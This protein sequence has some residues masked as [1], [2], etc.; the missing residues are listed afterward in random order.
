MRTRHE[1]S[2]GNTG[3]AFSNKQYLDAWSNEEDRGDAALVKQYTED[4]WPVAKAF[5]AHTRH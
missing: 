2:K 4:E 3:E 1:H 5:H